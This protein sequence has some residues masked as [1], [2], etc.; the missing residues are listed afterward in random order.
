ME[1]KLTKREKIFV[2]VI[3]VLTI[4]LLVCISELMGSGS[5]SAIPTDS[6]TTDNT[7]ASEAETDSASIPAEEQAELNEISLE[8]YL[9]LK[10]GEN[11]SIIY[12][13]RPTCH[14]CNIQEPIIKHLVYKYGIPVNYLDTD[15]LDA[16]GQNTLMSSDE[17]FSNGLSTPTTLIVQ[18]NQIVDS[19]IGVMSI[20]ESTEF[21][22]KYGFIE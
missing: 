12:I 16:D 11:A 1:N 15:K 8:D 14:Y 13:A 6:L 20:N 18:N 4:A 21:F 17:I 10:A 7:Q 2:G 22:K 5:D 3:V 9:N 19:A